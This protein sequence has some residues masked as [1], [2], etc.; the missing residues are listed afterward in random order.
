[1]NLQHRPLRRVAALYDLHGHLPALEAILAEA[2]NSGAELVVVGGDVFPG[3]LARDCLELLRGQPLPCRFLRGNG[4]NDVLAA[5]AGRPLTRVPEAYRAPLLWHANELQEDEA[6]WIAS[7][8]AG[9]QLEIAGLGRVLF[10]H[11]TPRDDNEL[12]T[13]LTPD[14]RLAPAF[15][16]VDAPLVICGHT[17]MP[18]DR[19]VHHLRVVNAGSAGMPFGTGG[20][21]WLL[22]G[23]DVEPRHTDLDLDAA[24]ARLRAGAYPQLDFI[25]RSLRAPPTIDA[26]T[27]LFERAALRAGA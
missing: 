12:F 14:A 1:M 25:E 24:I 4:E 11:A 27:E 6:A 20:A 5:R 26:M 16:G 9:L 22:L 21:D 18:F 23:P 13:R 7:W 15:A 2:R 3:P 17:H 10:C 8:P 19:R